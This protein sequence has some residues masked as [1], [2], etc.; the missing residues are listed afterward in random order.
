MNHLRNFVAMF[1]SAL[2]LGASRLFPGKGSTLNKLE[3]REGR[4]HAKFGFQH[5]NLEER[6]APLI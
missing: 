5:G 4:S 3:I 1:V 2:V 6:G